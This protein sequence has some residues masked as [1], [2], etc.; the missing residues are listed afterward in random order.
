MTAILQMWPSAKIDPKDPAGI[1]STAVNDLSSEQIRYGIAQ[2][3]RSDRQYAL[4]PGQFRAIAMAFRA[5]PPKRELEITDNSPK[6][7][8]WEQTQQQFAA[9]LNGP[10]YEYWPRLPVDFPISIVLADVSYDNE[11]RKEAIAA[12]FNANHRFDKEL[13]DRLKSAFELRWRQT[14]A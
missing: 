2:M 3:A 10:G 5:P 14:H 4:N 7:I 11:E 6:T 1:W 8:A 9:Q 13:F 12:G